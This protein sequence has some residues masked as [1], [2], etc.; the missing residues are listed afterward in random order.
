MTYGEELAKQHGFKLIYKTLDNGT[1]AYT[2][3][4]TIFVN[5]LL[6][7]VR[8]NYFCGSDQQEFKNWQKGL[9]QL[10]KRSARKNAE[11]LLKIEIDEDAFDRV[12][13][14]KSHPIAV[15]KSRKQKR[16]IAVRVISQFGEES[17]KVVE[18]SGIS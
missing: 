10:A 13:G 16:R 18:V 14:Y 1:V 4:K 11:K 12:Y 5:D 3:K 2:V 17:T 8:R 7:E 9:S 6:P 15:E